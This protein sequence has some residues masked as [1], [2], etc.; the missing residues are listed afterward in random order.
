MCWSSWL[1]HPWVAMDTMCGLTLWRRPRP[2]WWKSQSVQQSLLQNV[3]NMKHLVS[4]VGKLQCLLNN[5]LTNKS[6]NLCCLGWAIRGGILPQSPMANLW[7]SKEDA[8]PCCYA[9]LVPTNPR[10]LVQTGNILQP[11]QP[12]KFQVRFYSLLLAVCFF[13]CFYS[14]MTKYIDFFYFPLCVNPFIQSGIAW[15]EFLNSNDNLGDIFAHLREGDMKGA[16]LLWLRYEVRNLL[17]VRT[18]K[19]KIYV[20]ISWDADKF[21]TCE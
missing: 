11:A 2:T 21:N 14:L 6:K 12:R 1:L 3:D 16:Q 4:V 10:S 5:I 18:R 17:N 13:C 15:I 9:L 8:K 19:K 7:D 20:L